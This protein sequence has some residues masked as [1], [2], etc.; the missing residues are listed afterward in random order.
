MAGIGGMRRERVVGVRIF[1]PADFFAFVLGSPY[2][3][4]SVR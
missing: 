1:V 3:I 4:I 2:G